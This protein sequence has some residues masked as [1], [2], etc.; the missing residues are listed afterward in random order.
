[1][2][3]TATAPP[4]PQTDAAPYTIRPITVDEYHRMLEAGI[5]YEKEPVE[6]LDGQLIAMPPEGSAHGAAVTGLT[7]ELV[8]RFD[9]RALVRP[10]NSL[11]ISDLTELQPDFAV[12]RYREDLYTGA[13]PVPSDVHFL[14]EVSHSTLAYDRGAKLRTYASAGILEVWVVDVER[15]RVEAYTEPNAGVYAKTRVAEHGDS[16]A[17]CAFPADVIAA[18]TFLR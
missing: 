10:G 6:L 17:P 8:K 7:A 11:R 15:K 13:L 1:M 4:A 9:G 18:A 3:A 5:L 2:A 16:L 14:I 12:V